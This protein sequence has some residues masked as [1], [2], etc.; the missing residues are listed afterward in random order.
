V[1]ALVPHFCV[2]D[3]GFPEQLLQITLVA[4]VGRDRGGTNPKPAAWYA[5]AI[6]ALGGALYLW[7]LR[8]FA[9]VGRGTP[10]Q[11]D[12]SAA[13]RCGFMIAGGRGRRAHLDGEPAASAAVATIRYQE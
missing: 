12:R 1:V 2:G 10:G 8:V 5:I 13:I 6:I 4:R 9:T 7:C 11:W 3:T